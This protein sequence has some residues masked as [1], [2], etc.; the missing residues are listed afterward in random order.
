MAGKNELADL[1]DQIKALRDEVARIRFPGPVVDPAPWP[2]SGPWDRWVPRR[3][4]PYPWPG[5][6]A[7][8]DRARFRVVLGLD[9]R[10]V[11]GRILGVA[12]AK[13]KIADVK[14]LHIGDVIG[15]G[16]P[17][18][19]VDPA[20]DD[21]GRWIRM[22]P[23]LVVRWK[24]PWV[25]DPAPFDA[26]RLN[27]IENVKLVDA[28]AQIKNMQPAQIKIDDLA[29]I[30]VRDLV[31]EIIGKPDGPEVDP[32]PL[33]YGRFAALARSQFAAQHLTVSDISSMGRDELEA[34][35][36]QLSADIARLEALR[37][38]A[39]NKLGKG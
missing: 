28:V 26:A 3:P 18:P 1:R 10:D 12:G 34:A 30:T 33:D 32:S 16:S 36:H 8:F 37:D 35:T 23:R 22:N 39:L 14:D 6:P 13:L 7:P 19:V 17:G 5:D 27:T 2:H 15:A 38:L 21:V 20:P 24:W 25:G 4:F 31:V 9:L 11:A 29:T